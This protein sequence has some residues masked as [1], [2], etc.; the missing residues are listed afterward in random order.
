MLPLIIG[1]FFL[2]VVMSSGGYLLQAV[3]TEKENRMVEVMMTSV[4]P[5]TMIGGKALGLVGVALTQFALWALLAVIGIVIAAQFLPV[6]RGLRVPWGFLGIAALYF[7]PAYA[8]VAAM[9][10]AVGGMVSEARQGQ[11]IA[12]VFNMM[13]VVPYF[14]WAV[15]EPSGTSTNAE[16]DL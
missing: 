13:F 10:T 6:L 16:A 4:S 11:Q 2:M 3:T 12:G 7:L 15:Y 14:P 5:F 9:M 1:F 8:L